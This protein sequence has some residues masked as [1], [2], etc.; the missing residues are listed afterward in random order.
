MQ[1][2]LFFVFF[3]TLCSTYA[4]SQ[5][6]IRFKNG[7]QV[8]VKILEMNEEFVRYKKLSYLDG[9]DINAPK[10]K[11]VSITY[12]NGETE[13][14]DETAGSA[15]A[16][17]PVSE[18][19][20]VAEPAPE[21]IPVAEPAPEPVPMAEPALESVPMAEPAP[22][23]IPVAEPA[24]VF[25]KKKRDLPSIADDAAD[26]ELIGVH[27]EK[28]KAKKQEEKGN[29]K[30]EASPKTKKKKE[31]DRVDFTMQVGLNLLSDASQGDLDFLSPTTYMELYLFPIS[32]L[33]FGV[34]VGFIYAT[35]SDQNFGWMGT[36]DEGTT[37]HNFI[38]PLYGS[39]K[40]RIGR[41]ATVIPYAKLDLGYAFWWPT[42]EITCANDGSEYSA[43]SWGSDGGFLVGVGAGVDLGILNLEFSLLRFSGSIET[44][45]RYSGN[46]YYYNPAVD[47]TFINF[48]IGFT[49]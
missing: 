32:W 11:V 31:R 21:P 26:A 3:A 47:F 5:D 1:K 8:E 12:A 22:E 19:I 36:Y 6:V 30:A 41:G 2:Y 45:Y 10:D 27:Q 37:A 39:F 15:V 48:T 34:G 43:Y 35:T 49:I 23:L 46:T 28:S 33:G 20:P 25:E 9:P 18:P 42:T 16:P 14:F 7:K 4:F 17:A 13:Y 38:M 29:V 24:P 40:F 44:K